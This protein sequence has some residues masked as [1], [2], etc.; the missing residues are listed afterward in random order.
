MQ[1]QDNDYVLIETAKHTFV[2]RKVESET[3]GADKVHIIS[4]ITEGENVVVKGGI[5]LN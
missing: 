5:F 4:G 1:E 3:A 2:R